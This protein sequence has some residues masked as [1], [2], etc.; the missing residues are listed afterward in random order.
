MRGMTPGLRPAL[1]YLR[2][3][4]FIEGYKGMVHPASDDEGTERSGLNPNNGLENVF[5]SDQS[6]TSH[7]R[8]SN[9]TEGGQLPCNP[10]L[11]KT[12]TTIFRCNS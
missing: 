7:P 11:K 5:L 10:K 4:H 8:K 12:M 2:A 3:F 6:M 9:Q 1:K